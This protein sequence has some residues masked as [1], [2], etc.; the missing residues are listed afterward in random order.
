M[1]TARAEVALLRASDKMRDFMRRRN[2][3][4]GLGALI[5]SLPSDDVVIALW[6]GG[7]EGGS[8]R[9]RGGTYILTNRELHWRNADG[10]TLR[11]RLSEVSHLYVSRSGRYALH[12]VVEHGGREIDMVFHG[13]DDKSNRG[14]PEFYA[15]LEGAIQ[16]AHAMQRT[17]ETAP[18]ASVAEELER[19]AALKDRGILTDGEFDAQK[20][21]LLG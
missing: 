19:L 6:W 2:R 18:K 10:E 8:V 12:C 21:T 5:D 3:E 4:E 17:T 7:P 14:A 16:D 1:M 15:A 11:I 9:P 13:E 20:R